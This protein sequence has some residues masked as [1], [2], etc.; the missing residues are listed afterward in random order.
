MTDRRLPHGEAD[1]ADAVHRYS[2]TPPGAFTLRSAGY[3][4]SSAKHAAQDSAFELMGAEAYRSARATRRRAPEPGSVLEV[5]RRAGDDRRYIVVNFVCPGRPSDLNFVL[6]FAE[7]GPRGTAGAALERFMESPPDDDEYRRER[8][9]LL[10]SCPQGPWL[11]RKALGRPAIVARKLDT[12]FERGDSYVEVTVDVGSSMVA[13][14]LQT[15]IFSALA[16]LVIDIGFTVEGRTD[17]ELPE[18]LIGGCRVHRV[19]MRQLVDG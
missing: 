6:Y 2:E 5:A 10:P 12:T 16:G 3:R 13:R 17:D 1:D 15:L 7:R 18:R 11:I 19:D 14:R 8:F 4:A 9:K